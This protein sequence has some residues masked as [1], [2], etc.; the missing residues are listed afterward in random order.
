MA[1]TLY[2]LWLYVKHLP[3][4][5]M[6]VSGFLIHFM[7]WLWLVWYIRP[8]EE[9]IFLHYNILFGVDLVGSWVRIFSLPLFGLFIL[10]TNAV[11]GWVFFSKDPFI[12]YIA[13][14]ISVLIQVFLF[15]AA[16]LL[17]FLNV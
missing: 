11:V 16:A 7:I 2:P 10:V 15:I 13:N 8:Q 1:Q 4:R 12:S 5:I 17:V 3:N 14:A 9:A 6:L